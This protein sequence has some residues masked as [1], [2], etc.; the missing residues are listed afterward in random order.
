[1]SSAPS[2]TQP[3]GRPAARPAGEPVARPPEATRRRIAPTLIIL[4]GGLTALGPMTIDLYLPALPHMTRELHTSQTLLQLTLTAAL[5]GLAA[6]QAVVGPLSDAVGRRR[7]LLVGLGTYAVASVVCA[8]APTIEVLVAGRVVQALGGAAGIVIARAIVRDL[9]S[10]REI[11]RLFSLLL[12]VTGLA[13]ILAPVVGGQLLR[14]GSWRMLF[15]VLTAFG[16]VL[17][18]GVVFGLR[19]TLPAERR[20]QGGAR[21][22]AHSYLR[23]ARD[24]SFLGYA[25]A[26][27]LGFAGMFAYISGSP[28][29]YQE[30]F[31]I[32]PQFYGVLFGLN[33]LGLMAFSQANGRLVRRVDPRRLLVIGQFTSLAGAV[34][35][36]L[37]AATSFGG[38]VGVL[39]PLFVAVASLGM[40]GPNAMALGLSQHPEMAGTASALIGTLQF[41][42]GALAGPLV[43]AVQVR[44]ALPMATV[45][46]GCVV[47]GILARVILTRPEESERAPEERS[48]PARP[49]TAS[50]EES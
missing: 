9:V 8:V 20:R 18:L 40:V 5:V 7:P 31:G 29:V 33:G 50:A 16:V 49:A 14:L 38:V 26:G 35:L 17:L 41:V 27:G 44:S 48:G 43:T 28:F 15:G 42:V 23:L 10:G 25:L 21:D 11:A 45:V 24:R 32:S 1:M 3:P 12:L 30:V 13:P 39:L 37:A 6:G 19:E 46:A 2:S 34:L 22:A 36:V 4:L 47:L